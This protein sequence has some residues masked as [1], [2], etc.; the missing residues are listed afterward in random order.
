VDQHQL[1]QLLLLL[2]GD[3]VLQ[4]ASQTLWPGHLLLLKVSP[5]HHQPQPCDSQL[6]V[7]LRLLDWWP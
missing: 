4:A 2:H 7:L 1:H 5:L 6:Q 3:L